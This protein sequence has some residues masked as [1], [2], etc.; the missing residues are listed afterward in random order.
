MSHAQL[1]GRSRLN[2]G[3]VSRNRDLSSLK[4]GVPPP[5]RDVNFDNCFSMVVISDHQARSTLRA[6]FRMAVPPVLSSTFSETGGQESIT[7]TGDAA[8]PSNPLEPSWV[9][10]FDHIFV[11]AWAL[12]GPTTADR[13]GEASRAV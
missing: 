4:V 1:H 12:V 3:H 13:A 10:V 5:Q 9:D 6:P 8:R 2:E 7:C 11:N